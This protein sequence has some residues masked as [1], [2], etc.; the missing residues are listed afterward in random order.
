MKILV[1]L[2]L[3]A[4]LLSCNKKDS[5]PESNMQDTTA[6]SNI[7]TPIESET[8]ADTISYDTIVVPNKNEADYAVKILSEGF[9]H[10]DE[11]WD[12]AADMKWFGLFSGKDGY[13]IANTEITVKNVNDPVLDETEND[14]TG[15]EVKAS[16]KD[17]ALV[18]ISGSEFITPHK[19]QSFAPKKT[20]LLPNE[21]VEFSFK[22]KNYRIYAKSKDYSHGK[23][24]VNYKLY[25]TDGTATTL[26]TALPQFDDTMVQIL[27]IGDIDGD[28]IP[29]LLL[30]NTSHYNVSSPTL[31]LSKPA[32]EK[33]LVKPVSIHTS[34]GC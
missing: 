25:I 33:E 29:D 15:K 28:D 23:E 5:Q 20:E 16:V 19:V 8:E 27:F 3:S 26:L 21:K 11:V 7:S 17:T 9:F 4:T 2:V 6:T 12:Y 24:I 18:L 1:L 30:D 13:Y 14:K 32:D 34:V 22:G 10:G 31:Y